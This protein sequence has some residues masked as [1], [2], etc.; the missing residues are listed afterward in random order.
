[1]AEL[2]NNPS[3]KAPL[4]KRE[5]NLR[6][7]KALEAGGV[8]FV[9]RDLL[10]GPRFCEVTPGSSMP[11]ASLYDSCFPADALG[12]VVNR[13]P[14]HTTLTNKDGSLAALVAYYRAGRLN[15]W[16]FIPYML[17]RASNAQSP[18]LLS[19]ASRMRNLWALSAASLH[20]ASPPNLHLPLH[21]SLSFHVPNFRLVAAKTDDGERLRLESSPAWRDFL[22]AHAEGAADAR[23]PADIQS[24]AN[25]WLLKPTNGSGGR[26]IEISSE[27]ARFEKALLGGGAATHAFLLQKYIETP[28]LY[29]G[30][31]CVTLRYLTSPC[32]A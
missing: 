19:H 26:G 18:A 6:C 28:L 32:L 21:T 15:P 13:W 4:S 1:M 22:R 16:A 29:Q 30:R 12:T 9:F 17:P 7:A 25:L 24:G 23:V 3:Q 8:S 10:N 31:K 5:E 20:C 14:R 11:M 2:P 27:V